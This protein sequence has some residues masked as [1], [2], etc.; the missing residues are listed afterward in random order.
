MKQFYSRDVILFIDLIV[1]N[2]Y[3]GTSVSVITD[4]GKDT[5]SGSYC[6]TTVKLICNVTNLPHLRWTYAYNAS[7]TNIIVHF[8]PDSVIPH[9]PN[10][11]FP[12]YQLTEF[13]VFNYKNQLL[14]N[15]STILTVD[16]SNLNKQNI[17]NIYCGSSAVYKT[18]PVNISILQPSFPSVSPQVYTAVIV[19]YE[20]GLVSS[21]DVSWR[22]FQ[23]S[24]LSL[25]HKYF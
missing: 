17:K 3:I 7:K 22:K 9:Y 11:A 2:N 13:S 1:D 20:S 4:D 23:V 6:P 15:A 8:Q 19:R 24:I 18:V 25:R 12:F 14:M 5:L 21:M 16:L 10:A